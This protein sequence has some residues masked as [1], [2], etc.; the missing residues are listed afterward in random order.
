MVVRDQWLLSWARPE[1]TAL[2]NALA[3]YRTALIAQ[4]VRAHA[5]QLRSILDRIGWFDIPIHGEAASQAAWLI[6]QHADHDPAWQRAM[7]SVLTPR[8][9]NGRFQPRYLAYL[10]DRVA[11]N[12]GEPQ[13]YATQGG[14]A[15]PGNW[16]P[17]TMLDPAN[18]GTRRA[19]VGL[20]PLADYIARFDCP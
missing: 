1:N 2:A 7:L 12:A 4:T 16:Q 10:T 14:C 3:P 8:A 5:A 19:S 17:R 20:G 15:G 6:I 11:V 9:A 18:V 13:T